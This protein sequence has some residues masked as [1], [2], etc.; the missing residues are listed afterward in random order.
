MR[1]LECTEE[2][3]CYEC[4]EYLLGNGIWIGDENPQVPKRALC[5]NCSLKIGNLAKRMELLEK[6]AKI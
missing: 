6:N 4:G 5:I 2:R 1:T 3:R